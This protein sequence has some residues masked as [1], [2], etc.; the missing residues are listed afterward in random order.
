MEWNECQ[1]KKPTPDHTLF[2]FAL[3]LVW[4]E[5]VPSVLPLIVLLSFRPHCPHSRVINPLPTEHSF[6]TAGQRG[7]AVFRSSISMRGPSPARISL[8]LCRGSSSSNLIYRVTFMEAY[9]KRESVGI[10]LC[11]SDFSCRPN[12]YWV[13]IGVSQELILFWIICT[14]LLA[15]YSVF[16]DSYRA[17]G[18][19]LAFLVGVSLLNIDLISVVAPKSFSR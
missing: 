5:T 16:S 19:S 9:R 11:C 14:K 7:R 2:P 3:E 4:C 6:V 13:C 18:L 10:K 12:G 8:E 1:K 15:I 17:L